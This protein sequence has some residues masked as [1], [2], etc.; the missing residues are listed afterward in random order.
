MSKRDF[1]E[2][3]IT[4]RGGDVWRLRFRVD[5]RRRLKTITGTRVEAQKELRRLLKSIDDGD[6]VAPSRI[7]LK[8]WSDQWLTLLAR[9][10]PQ[11]GGAAKSA[12]AREKAIAISCGCTC[13]RRLALGDYSK[14]APARSTGSISI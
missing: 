12:L 6:A 1:G 4:Q 2:G 5:G 11:G 13:C 10:E 7:T 3:A 14:S 9:G 8:Q